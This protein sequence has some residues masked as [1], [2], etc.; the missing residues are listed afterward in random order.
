MD[1]QL[2]LGSADNKGILSLLSAIEQTG[3]SIERPIRSQYP[4]HVI[5]LDQSEASHETDFNQ[6]E[7]LDINERSVLT[8]EMTYNF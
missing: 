4:D 7:S 6:L 5:T 3:D 2:G 1:P 8:N